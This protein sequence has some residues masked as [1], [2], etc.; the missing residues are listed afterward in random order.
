MSTTTTVAEGASSI[1]TTTIDPKFHMQGW[2]WAHITARRLY[3]LVLD[4]L[5]V[6]APKTTVEIRDM[7]RAVRSVNAFLHQHHDTEE[8]IV[9]P[10]LKQEKPESIE[11]LNHLDTQH[12]GWTSLNQEADLI[13]KD[14][15][16]LSKSSTL[17][18]EEF[19]AHHSKLTANLSAMVE[20]L[21]IHFDDEERT[22]MPIVTTLPKDKQIKVTNT[23]ESKVRSSPGVRFS[24]F[25]MMDTCKHEPVMAVS[26]N[27][28]VPFLIRKL[29]PSLFYNKEYKWFLAI[30]KL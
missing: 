18:P 14:L 29:A 25:A 26:F 2:L 22:L 28:S 30:T 5:R 13:L 7:V 27:N 10:W 6:W 20:A 19:A 8:E 16:V 23:V 12:H 15:D 21:F 9:W 3:T 1:E 4:K 17:I 24:L 11:L